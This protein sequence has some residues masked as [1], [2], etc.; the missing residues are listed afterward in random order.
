MLESPFPGDRIAFFI[1]EHVPD[2]SQLREGEELWA[3]VTVPPSRHV[4]PVRLGIKKDGVLK[5]LDL[6]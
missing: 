2:P 4:R 1:P 6:R 3:E 5:P